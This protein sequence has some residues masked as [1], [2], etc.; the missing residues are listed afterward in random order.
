MCGD[1]TVVVYHAR[2]TLGGVVQGRPAG[3]K[4]C[5]FQIHTGF[6]HEEETTLRLSRNQLD[7]VAITSEGGDLHGPNFMASLSFFVLD[8]ERTVQPEP[9]G[10]HCRIEQNIC[11]NLTLNLKTGAGDNTVKNAMVLFTS[12]EEINEVFDTFCDVTGNNANDVETFFPVRDTDQHVSEKLYTPVAASTSPIRPSSPVQVC[13]N[14]IKCISDA[15]FLMS[16]IYLQEINVDLLNLGS[17]S[18]SS[19]LISNQSSGI[20][21]GELLN[22]SSQTSNS[23]LVGS[24]GGGNGEILQDLLHTSEETSPA[25]ASFVS[26]STPAN[27]FFTLDHFDPLVGAPAGVTATPNNLSSSNSIGNFA[28]LQQSQPSDESLMGNWDS[29]LKQTPSSG[30]RPMTLPSIPRNS[31]TPNLEA[32]AKDPLADFGNLIGL[33][34]TT[35][36]NSA[37][38]PTWGSSMKPIP[39]MNIGID[40][41]IVIFLW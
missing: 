41:F 1:I 25:T 7:E 26:T 34:G 8:Q 40:F 16:L 24:R 39:P 33:A 9:W 20:E 12:R 19:V 29:I 2:N 27:P 21:E 11:K 22:L 6:I 30:S 5:Q 28:T 32:K 4:I 15:L 37:R 38:A 3:L 31:S 23:F 14:K 18:T 36:S 10:K 13:S 17:E 35:N